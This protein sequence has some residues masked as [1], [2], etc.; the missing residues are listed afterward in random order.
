MFWSS[1]TRIKMAVESEDLSRVTWFQGTVASAA[2]PASGP[3]QGSPWRMLQ[4]YRP[5]CLQT[6]DMRSWFMF[7]EL[8]GTIARTR[9][10]RSTTQPLNQRNQRAMVIEKRKPWR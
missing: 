7:E 4:V 1:G 6:S 3:W 8:H 2:V 10:Q 5:I 9:D